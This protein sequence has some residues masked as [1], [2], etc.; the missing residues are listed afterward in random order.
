M[1]PKA[2]QLGE[3]ISSSLTIRASGLR[4]R[5]RLVGPV[6][7]CLGQIR[8]VDEKAA[9]LIRLQPCKKSI[10]IRS[11]GVLSLSQVPLNE[12][13]L[14]WHRYHW[15]RPICSFSTAHRIACQRPAGCRKHPNGPLDPRQG[16]DKQ[17]LG[18]LINLVS[19][20]GLGS[21]ADRAR[22]ILGRV[23]EYFLSQFAGRRGQERGQFYTPTHV[24]RVLVEMPAINRKVPTGISRLGRGTVVTRGFAGCMKWW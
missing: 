3:G 22:D 5:L 23:Y 18:Q 19:D 24:V 6:G 21:P 9:L 16:L 4:Q 13:R 11:Q 14:V 20:I 12:P 1:L 8:K 15:R 17:R 2:R 7:Q 10:T